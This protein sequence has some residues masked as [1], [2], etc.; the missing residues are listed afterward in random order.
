MN[1]PMMESKTVHVT[2]PLIYEVRAPEG[3]YRGEI[4]G[5]PAWID[6]PPPTD[7]EQIAAAELAGEYIGKA[8]ID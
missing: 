6:I 4:D 7:E 8:A 3:K 1:G 5:M 2:S